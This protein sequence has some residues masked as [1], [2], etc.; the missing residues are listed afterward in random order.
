MVSHHL[1]L[2][3]LLLLSFLAMPHG[4]TCY[5]GADGFPV[6]QVPCPSGTCATWIQNSVPNYGCFSL[7]ECNAQVSPY[8]CQDD[9][10][11]TRNSHLNSLFTFQF[12]LESPPPPPPP[13]LATPQAGAPTFPPSNTDYPYTRILSEFGSQWAY[14]V[15]TD[16]SYPGN[17][18]VWTSQAFNDSSWSRARAPIGTSNSG[19]FIRSQVT[20]SG[21]CLYLRANMTVDS[22][23]I[24]L[25]QRLLG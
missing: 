25:L 11:N 19:T 21:T 14:F 6:S 2:L 15:P 23:T 24:T 1:L 10:C 12:C 5:S 17:N 8:C 18:S 13:P 9:L 7:T 22:D 3:L 20:V 4:L 16:A